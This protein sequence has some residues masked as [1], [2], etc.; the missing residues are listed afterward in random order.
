M[1]SLGEQFPIEQAR[2]REVLR[3]YE[4]CGPGGELG[5]M[6]IRQTLKRADQAA[7]SGDVI[8]MIR[9]FQEMKETQ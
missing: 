7:I 8:E 1:S 9:A 4:A 2:V 3:Q 5:A 6:F